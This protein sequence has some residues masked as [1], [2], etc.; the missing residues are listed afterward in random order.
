[1]LSHLHTIPAQSHIQTVQSYAYT[2]ITVRKKKIE[3]NMRIFVIPV[4][5]LLG[6]SALDSSRL[7]KA[8]L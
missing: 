5:P 6:F 8:V 3:K 2:K 7:L 4:F 1:M